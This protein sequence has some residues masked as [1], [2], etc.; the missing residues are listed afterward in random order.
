MYGDVLHVQ[1]Q[2][3]ASP[4]GDRGVC[5]SLVVL[6]VCLLRYTMIAFVSNEQQFK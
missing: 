1:V 5:S 3:G 4:P 2:V 6:W